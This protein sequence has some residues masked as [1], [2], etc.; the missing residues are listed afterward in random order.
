M[1]RIGLCL[2]AVMMSIPFSAFAHPGHA[3]ASELPVT[4]VA[5]VLS[6]FAFIVAIFTSIK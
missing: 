3:M 5:I 1:L 6:V 2:V 4:E